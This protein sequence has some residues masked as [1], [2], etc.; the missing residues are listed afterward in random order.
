[1][2][3]SSV[4]KYLLIEKSLIIIIIM[5]LSVKWWIVEMICQYYDILN[6]IYLWYKKI[7]LLEYW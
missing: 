5:H 1:M 4:Q 3:I 2:K 7:A 6:A